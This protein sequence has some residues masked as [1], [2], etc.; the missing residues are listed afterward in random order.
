MTKHEATEG[1]KNPPSTLQIWLASAV[2][3]AAIT[4]LGNWKIETIRQDS[5][6]MQATLQ[7]DIASLNASIEQQKADLEQERLDFQKEVELLSSEFR[8]QEILLEQQRF[9]EE[10][11]DRRFEIV[12]AYVPGLVSLD[13]SEM[14]VSLAVLFELYPN[15]ARDILTRVAESQGSGAATLLR[16]AIER[17][18]DVAALLQPAIERAVMLDESTGEWT[19]VISSAETLDV[20]KDVAEAAQESKYV[21]TIY[22]IG[23]YYAT[24]VGRFP[25]RG[26]AESANIAVRVDLI[27]SAFVMNLSNACPEPTFYEV[28]GFYGCFFENDE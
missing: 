5:A 16:P 19:I 4:A 14:K 20:A 12:R 28:S 27:P 23:E 17:G 22:R 13:K 15:D 24:T 9:E 1:K 18:D 25:S 8:R 10:L 3:A 26:D 2:M 21:A 11:R 6:E 7:E